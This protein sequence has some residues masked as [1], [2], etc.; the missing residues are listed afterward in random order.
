MLLMYDINSFNVTTEVSIPH[1]GKFDLGKYL[2]YVT[3]PRNSAFTQYYQSLSILTSE[4][5]SYKF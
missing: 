2:W 1:F 5:E 3:L 4:I